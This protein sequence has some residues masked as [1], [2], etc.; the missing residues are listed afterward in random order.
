VAPGRSRRHINAA[1]SRRAAAR[2]RLTGAAPPPPTEAVFVHLQRRLA[3]GPRTCASTRIGQR[4]APPGD[5][6]L[7]GNELADAAAGSAAASFDAA[8][9]PRV[10][11]RRRVPGRRPYP[12]M[13]L[14]IS[15]QHPQGAARRPRS[16]V[17][18]RPTARAGATRRCQPAHRSPPVP[19][20][21]PSTPS[22]PRHNHR[23]PP[24][25]CAA[26]STLT[27]ALRQHK[28]DWHPCWVSPAATAVAPV[29]AVPDEHP[30]G[31]AAG[32]AHLFGH[33]ESG[34]FCSA[35]SVHRANAA[36]SSARI[37]AVT[38]SRRPTE[39][40]ASANGLLGCGRG[41]PPAAAAASPRWRSRPRAAV[42]RASHP[43]RADRHSGPLIAS[44]TIRGGGSAPVSRR[45]L[46]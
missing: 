18:A 29:V 39:R 28:I 25:R 7:A 43:D 20:Q 42:V 9:R 14:G 34:P 24:R 45:G 23:V 21:R 12:S 27:Q 19:P 13:P 5:A 15:S 16:G 17:P 31:R 36:V 2:W 44:T 41:A 3:P 32:A 46:D 8:Q 40:H 4:L 10:G 35:A 33:R 26:Q 30:R 38:I 22:D 37:S 11:R 6:N 1:R